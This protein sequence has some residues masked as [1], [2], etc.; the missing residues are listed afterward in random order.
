[1]LKVGVRKGITGKV[2]YGGSDPW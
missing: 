1:L 2:S